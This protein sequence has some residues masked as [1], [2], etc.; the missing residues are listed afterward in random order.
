MSIRSFFS[1][2]GGELSPALIIRRVLFLLLL[3]F[4]AIFYLVLN[5]RGLTSD[6]GIDQAQ[7]AREISRGKGFVTKFVRPLA[8]YQ[9]HSHA[10]ED[11]DKSIV[12]F[13][14]TY[15]APL[16]PLLNSV[17]M[18]F[19]RGEDDWKWNPKQ[20]VYYLDR[21]I[22]GT[23]ILLLLC[24]IGINYLLVSRIFDTK[25]G[26]VT[27]L[28]MLLC[29]L[30]WQFSQS[31]LPQMLML[32]LFSF[33]MYFLYKAMECQQ[34]EEPTLIWLCLTA[35]F[36]GLLALA[37]WI[38]IWPFIGLVI[39][40]AFHFKPRGVG[41]ATMLGIFLVTVSFWAV[42]NWNLTGTPL[43][44]GYFALYGGLNDAEETVMRNFQSG[45]DMDA[46][47]LPTR[48][49]ITSLRQIDGLY[50][51]LGSILAAP[52]FFIS[53]LHPFKR[54]E[55]GQFRWCILL[56]WVFAVFGMSLFGLPQ[57]KVDSN[58]LHILFTP[59]MTGYGL[60]MLSVL[61]SRLGITSPIPLLANGHLIIVV[62]VSAIPTF[63]TMPQNV[64]RG[65]IMRDMETASLQMSYIK[66]KIDEAEIIVTDAPWQ[67]AWYGDRTALWLP[68]TIAQFE[69]IDK[70]TEKQK[71]PIVGIVITSQAL[72]EP[73]G[74]V[75]TRGP[76]SEWRAPIIEPLIPNIQNSPK[77][78]Y[79]TFSRKLSG[80]RMFFYT[81]P[82]RIETGS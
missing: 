76:Y 37:H 7:I 66:D 34:S 18:K 73:I 68:S 11:K 27:A 77:T 36:F 75:L 64:R 53:L 6:K 42:R 63:I 45:Q 72:M 39:F 16:N 50:S 15:H 54:R 28:L 58:Q 20:S 69:N 12:N 9:V 81:L 51:F 33:A 29:E 61:W 48:L 13:K 23:S 41:A 1:T 47:G 82:E 5:F 55:I 43:G 17:V 65:L 80:N 79:N 8:L 2:S 30:M 44:S 26:G 3:T 52:L 49:L 4:L 19:F 74:S 56:M 78:R 25:I 57:G 46:K 67:I 32:F 59:L 24:S 35:C 40:S 70:F 31:G 10:D 21:V 14:D 60:A 22:A 71:Q 38:A 62:V